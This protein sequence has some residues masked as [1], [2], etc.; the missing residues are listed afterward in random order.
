[1]RFLALYG[2]IGFSLSVP[3]LGAPQSR[4]TAKDPGER[5][6]RAARPFPAAEVR[7]LDG[8]FKDAFERNHAYLLQLYPDRLLHN[9]RLNAG[10]P[11][12]AVPLGGW[13]RPDC[14][15]RGH[16]TGHYL[17]AS[18]LMV[19]ASGDQSL[20][21]NA[22]KVVAGLAECQKALGTSG[23]LSAF[24]EEFIDRVET[25]KKVWAP[26]YTLHKIYAGLLDMYLL[27]GERQALDVLVKAVSWARAR[28]DRL[29]D[30]HMQAML[31]VE[32]GGM[33]EVLANL[34]AVT[35]NPD[36]LDLARRFEKKSFTEP[37]AGQRD[38][39]RGLHANTHIPQA[40]AA[41]R[42]YE[43]TGDPRCRTIAS[44]FWDEVVSRR[45]YVTG[46]TS[47]YEHWR[48][49]PGELADELSVET[50]ENC[51]SYNMLKLSRHLFSWTADARVAD[52]YERTILNAILPTQKT[53]DGGGLMYYVPLKAGLFKMFGV[54]D[55]SY[56][57]CNGT[58]IESFATLG[59]SIYFH[60]SSG[61]FVNLYVTSELKW[62]EKGVLLRQRTAFPEQDT[63]SFDLSM[64]KPTAFDLRL[65]IPSWVKGNVSVSLNGV[66]QNLEVTA[67]KYV[68]LARTW[69]DNDRIELRLP[70][71]LD[72][73][74][75]P[76][77][78]TLAA[79]TFGPVVMAGAL[80]KEIMTPGMQDGFGLPDVE[81][82]FGE[83]AAI[84]TPALVAPRGPL[85]QWITPVEGKPLTFRTRQSGQPQD[86]TLI[87]FYRLF[88][89]RYTIYW[90]LYDE[91]GWERIQN[92][93]IRLPKETF[94]SV[95]VGDMQ[96]ERRHN[97][98]AFE[99]VRGETRKRQWVKSPLWF[100]YDVNVNPGRSMVLHCT[101]AGKEKDCLF[102]ITIDGLPLAT[103]DLQG[104]DTG[105]AIHSAYAIPSSMIA[106]KN[107]VAVKF[108]ARQG[109]MTG[110]V[111]GLSVTEGG[112]K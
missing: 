13:E 107:R 55:S 54:P 86:V 88:H 74:P 49:G 76:D 75:M 90:D 59:S 112:P 41:A 23:Y 79:V 73:W 99:S 32:F 11:T 101:Y 77:D 64:E 83:G 68:T 61:L 81:R 104:E 95:C 29:D 3:M 103:Q 22:E 82:M 100:R 6:V 38:E 36:H 84:E 93:R 60:D 56:W 27:C 40:I 1:M 53:E 94:D 37:L 18:A 9:F 45:T 33:G 105:E 25:G 89:Q 80:G 35:G 47:N 30:Q 78:S 4:T 52:Y 42:L 57:C 67:G 46:G 85:E 72:F 51:C 92:A 39:L 50:H 91:Q 66:V 17:S 5:I 43:L 24:P 87:P 58:G 20:R 110:A 21:K 26:W 2:F 106:G 10:L 109:T 102:D 69:K 7:L 12:R 108:K 44:F 31:N 15:L 16:F 65:R 14:E 97:F 19:A 63:S 62:Q 71:G 70:M 28:T 34:Y 111:L 48:K 96:C 8:P 98:Q